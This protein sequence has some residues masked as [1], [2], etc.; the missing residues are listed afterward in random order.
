[1]KGTF[2]PEVSFKDRTFNRRK[3]MKFRNFPIIA[4]LFL[5]LLLWAEGAV[6]VPSWTGLSQEF[7]SVAEEVIPVIVSISSEKVVKVKDSPFSREPFKDFFGDDFFGRFFRIPT[8]QGEIRQRGLGSGVIV[9]HDGYILTNSHLVSGAEKIWVTLSDERKFE[10]KIV[11]TDAKSDVGVIRI[12]AH[13]LPVA[14]LGDSD[15]V[16]V[17]EW[18]LAIGNP[19]RLAHTVTAGII[20]AKGRSS[21]GLAEYED[22]I[23]T[24]AAINP[25][26]SGGALTNLKGE[27][28]GI[29][30]AI[31][32]R[33]GGYQGVGFAIPV[34]MAK[35]VMDQLISTGKVIRGWLGVIIQDVDSD[36]AEALGLERAEGVLIG[37]VKKDSPAEEGGIKREDVIIRFDNQK[38]DGAVGLK[39]MVAGRKPGT[40]VKVEV[41]RDRRKKDLLIELG[42]MPSSD[43]PS[44]EAPELTEKLGIEVEE[45]SPNLA[46][47]LG[48]SG[49]KGV[50]VVG[51][52][53][54][55]LAQL[56]GIKRGDL[57]QEINREKIK[58]LDDY[59][60][61]LGKAKKGESIL[62][63]VRRGEDTLFVA[64]RVPKE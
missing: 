5:L 48:Y 14:K 7:S 30:T 33:S 2:P 15:K 27:V 49:Q 35:E 44:V 31:A 58:S 57:I 23:Q 3:K 38:V 1:M 13:N 26:N 32:T 20:S 50:V 59:N 43:S 45:L 34:N 63:L 17:G 46:R 56:A 54:S 9:S 61:A 29:N 6:T 18:V 52:E 25:G 47:R 21:V 51:V 53:L 12:E 37:D 60:R 41:L 64:V 19:F 28:I 42:E 10:A 39:H 11:G 40:E 4:P 22:F 24:D 16:K 55:S 8:P 36:M 62:F